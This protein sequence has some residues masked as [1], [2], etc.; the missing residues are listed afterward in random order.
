MTYISPHMIARPAEGAYIE[1]IAAPA[2]NF[3]FGRRPAEVLLQTRLPFHGS[4][5]S[6]QARNG[7]GAAASR[8]LP[9]RSVY[10]I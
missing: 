6:F 1:R 2:K 10:P 7:S 5:L 9:S 3:V 4:A 8:R